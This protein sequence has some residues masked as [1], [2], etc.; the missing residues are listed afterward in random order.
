MYIVYVTAPMCPITPYGIY[1]DKEE[2]LTMCE[3]TGYLQ[4]RYAPD[5]NGLGKLP[6][7]H[8]TVKV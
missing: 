1:R 8:Q 6:E 7:M 4:A 2:A 5:W 3:K